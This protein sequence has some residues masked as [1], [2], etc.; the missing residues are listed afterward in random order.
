M[1]IQTTLL[2]NTKLL[3]KS[4]RA[5]RDT[6]GAKLVHNKYNP[7]LVYGDQVD[8][9]EQYKYFESKSDNIV[10]LAYTTDEKEAKTWLEEGNK[11][12]GRKTL[13]GCAGSGIVLM[14]TVDEFVPGLKVYTVY[15][16]KKKEFR[17]HIFKDRL[18][19][20][21]EK[22]RKTG[23]QDADKFIRSHQRGW[24]F[25]HTNVEYD[26]SVVTMA[27]EARKITKSDFVGVDVGWNDHYQ[28]A[29]IIEVNS[30]PGIE[31]SSVALYAKTIKEYFAS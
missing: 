16:K 7:V 19:T 21:L 20:V 8:K 26:P 28:Q 17:V 27:L 9:L 30:A 18:V 12:V 24:V 3:S 5:L 22:R 23:V 4:M 6:L 29:F 1:P 25:C 10:G 15:R 2:C 31:G 11:V 13:C 14:S